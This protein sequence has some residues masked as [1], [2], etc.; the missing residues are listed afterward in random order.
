MRLGRS[1]SWAVGLLF[2]SLTA[3]ADTQKVSNVGYAVALDR[4]QVIDLP[5]GRKIR[6]GARSHGSLVDQNTKEE[7]S[8]WCT[9]EAQL[10]AAGEE[11][12]QVGYCA[13]VADNGDTL[14]LS[15]FIPGPQEGGNWTVIAGTGRYE[16]ATGGGTTAVASQRGDGYAW[17]TKS[18]GTLTTK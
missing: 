16:G 11:T 3:S 1:S 13:V 15:F 8:Q 10:N 4:G 14:W 9:A 2:F 18:T 6:V 17:T 12:S 5:N 7:S